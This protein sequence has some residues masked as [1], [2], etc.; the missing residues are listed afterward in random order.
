MHVVARPDDLDAGIGAGARPRRYAPGQAVQRVIIST[1]PD[2]SVE[3]TRRLVRPGESR[4]LFR[5]P[6]V[7]V[8][9]VAAFYER[10]VVRAELGAL[11][12]LGHL[13]RRVENEERQ[14]DGGA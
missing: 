11:G 3:K 6:R 5:R 2:R 12:G 14:A 1:A 13:C 7:V 4:S 9:G 10:A 8:E